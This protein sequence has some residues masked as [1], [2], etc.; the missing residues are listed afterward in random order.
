MI[1]NRVI[2][3]SSMMNIEGERYE[4]GKEYS[5]EVKEI[6]V[7]LG[8]EYDYP[9]I[10]HLSDYGDKIVYI[11]SEQPILFSDEIDVSAYRYIITENGAPIYC[12]NSE[13]E[14]ISLLNYIGI[15]TPYMGHEVSILRVTDNQD[16]TVIYGPYEVEAN[17]VTLAK[18]E[19]GL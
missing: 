7:L 3:C 4:V 1:I 10:R 8:C 17:S 12:T 13:E 6:T 15:D 19:L 18:G 16:N 5:E 9:E 14:I 2:N 11:Y